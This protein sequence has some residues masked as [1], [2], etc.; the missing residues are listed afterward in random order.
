[1]Y[2]QLWVDRRGYVVFASNW[3]GKKDSVIV[4]G[5]LPFFFLFW[6]SRVVLI[7]YGVFELQQGPHAVRDR[8]AV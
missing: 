1:M 5:I 3:N 8:V 4:L 6:G 2:T 7:L